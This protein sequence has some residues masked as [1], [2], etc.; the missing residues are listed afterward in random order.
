[1]R[2]LASPRGECVIRLARGR[3]NADSNQQATWPAGYVLLQ[4]RRDRL[5]DYCLPRK[6]GQ[7]ANPRL[8]HVTDCSVPKLQP[9]IRLTVY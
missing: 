2:H 7:V 1:M 3:A 6:G 5:G 4:V 9:S 8:G